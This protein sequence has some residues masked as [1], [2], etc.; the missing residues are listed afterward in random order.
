MDR[1]ERRVRVVLVSPGDVS[2]LA[3]HSAIDLDW[4]ATELNDRPRKRLGFSK[5]IEEIGP[6]LLQ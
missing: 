5:P 1:S 6:L 2:D 4:V 3:V